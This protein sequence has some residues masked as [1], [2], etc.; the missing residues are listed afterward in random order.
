MFEYIQPKYFLKMMKNFKTEIGR[1]RTTTAPGGIRFLSTL[2]RGKSLWEF[3]YLASQVSCMTHAHLNFIRA[4]LLALFFK[5]NAL[6]KRKHA[7]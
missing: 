2:L 3:D 7:M 6:T 5:I 1:I 4:G